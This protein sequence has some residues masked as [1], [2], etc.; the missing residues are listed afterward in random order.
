MSEDDSS[1]ASCT[2]RHILFAAKNNALCYKR[3]VIKMYTIIKIMT[4]WST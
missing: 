4:V 1:Q 2:L 3:I